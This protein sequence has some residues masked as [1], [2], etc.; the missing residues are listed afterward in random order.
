MAT[1]RRSRYATSFV[2]GMLCAN[3]LPHLATAVSDHQHLTPIGGRRSNRWVNLA[4]G[5]LNLGGGLAL[6]AT[7][8]GAGGRWDRRL[9]AFDAGAVTFTLWMALSEGLL[10]INSR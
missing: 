10:P 8:Q 7:T 2:A 9:V 1:T 4:W 5:A 3:S 6:A